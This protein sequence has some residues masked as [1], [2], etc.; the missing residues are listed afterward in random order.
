MFVITKESDELIGSLIGGAHPGLKTDR[1]YRDREIISIGLR[2]WVSPAYQAP[3]AVISSSDSFI[4]VILVGNTSQNNDKRIRRFGNL[5]LP[6][7]VNN[8]SSRRLPKRLIRLSLFWLVF[9]TRITIS[10]P[11]HLAFTNIAIIIFRAA[12]S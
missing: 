11:S 2:S 12:K 9:P 10:L 3:D 6:S 5:R 7:S 4:M 1:D 8:E